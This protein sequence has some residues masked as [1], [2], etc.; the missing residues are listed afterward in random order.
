MD[1]IDPMTGK[2]GESEKV[3]FRREPL[4]F[5]AAHLTWGRGGVQ[6]CR[7]ADDPAHRGIMT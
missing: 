1:A 5:E 6:R 4:G 3:L 2:I 7:A